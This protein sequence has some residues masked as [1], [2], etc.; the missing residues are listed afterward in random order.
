MILVTGESGNV[1]R[2]IVSLRLRAGDS[3]RPLTY[4]P[5]LDA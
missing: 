2:H 3:A 5:G 4:D 1:G